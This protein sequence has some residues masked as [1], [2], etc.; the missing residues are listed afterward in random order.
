[1]QTDPQHLLAQLY[2]YQD[3]INRAD[4][5]AAASLFLD[6]ASIEEEGVSYPG[7]RAVLV[8][9]FLRGSSDSASDPPPGNR[10]TRARYTS[11]AR[12]SSSVALRSCRRP[13]PAEPDQNPL[14]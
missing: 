14:L 9:S 6:T 13:P 1:M 12:W 4:A 5:D 3:A 10:P 11:K 7:V 8:E 2:A